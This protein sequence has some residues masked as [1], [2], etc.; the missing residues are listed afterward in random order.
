VKYSFLDGSVPFYVLEENQA[1]TSLQSFISTTD[2]SLKPSFSQNVAATAVKKCWISTSEHADEL[3]PRAVKIIEDACPIGG[4]S[5]VYSSGQGQIT[6][7]S[8]N[9]ETPE[10][11]YL[12]F[13][14]RKN[15]GRGKVR[16]PKGVR[17]E[18]RLQLDALRGISIL[19]WGTGDCNLGRNLE[20]IS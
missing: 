2:D 6:R 12:K 4:S 1:W 10:L 14:V 15:L 7:I 16:S 11:Q 20:Q 17:F 5:N 8:F 9:C 18:I 19:A 13:T 3:F